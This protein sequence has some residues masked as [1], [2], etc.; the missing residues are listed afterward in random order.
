MPDGPLRIAQLMHSASR[1]NTGVFTAA[2][3]LSIA[4]RRL[5][6]LELEIFAVEDEHTEE[7]R[8]QWHGIRVNASPKMGPTVFSYAPK[9]N[10]KLRTFL[11]HVIHQHGLWTY[12]SLVAHRLSRQGL[13]GVVISVHGMLTPWALH[14]NRNRK[15]IA[16]ALREREPCKSRLLACF[17]KG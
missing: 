6:G 10:R 16:L 1:N 17:N 2:C 7:D 15:K 5:S 11:P 14:H 4:L 9:I 12:T 3:G 8:S 13:S